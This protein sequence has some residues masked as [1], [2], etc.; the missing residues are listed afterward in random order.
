MFKTLRNAFSL[1]ELRRK[2]LYVVFIIVL[3]RIGSVIPVPYISADAMNYIMSF[4]DGSIFD[5]ALTML[6]GIVSGTYSTLFIAAPIMIWWYRGK[7]P[8]FDKEES[9]KQG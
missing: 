5:F 2:M 7:R 4:G 6:I 8:Q 1:P 3:Y 9:Q